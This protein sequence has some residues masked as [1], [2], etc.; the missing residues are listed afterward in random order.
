[1]ACADEWRAAG[2]LVDAPGRDL[3]D[4]ADSS[5]V[6]SW[7]EKY[8]RLDLCVCNAGIIAD[9]PLAKMAEARWDEVMEVNLTGAMRCARAAAKLM[10]RQRGGHIIFISSYSAYCPPAGQANYAAA[11]AALEGLAKSLAKELGGRGIRVNV[12][13]PGFLD[14]KMTASVD[15]M[16]RQAALDKHVLNELNSPLRVA[17]FIRFLDEEMLQTSGQ[18]FHLDSRIL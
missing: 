17:R 13:V 2:W 16:V 15:P 14:T 1:M 10:L 5:S 7:F 12:V 4:V 9:G 8:D 18:V 3:L 11:K 6:Q